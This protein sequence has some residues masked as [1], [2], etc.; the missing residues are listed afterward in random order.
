MPDVSPIAD[1][2]RWKIANTFEILGGGKGVSDQLLS[3]LLDPRSGTSRGMLSIAVAKSKNRSAIPVLLNMLEENDFPG[4]AAQGLG[5]LR[6][7]EAVPK[8]R[9][10]AKEHGN[11]WVRQQAKTALRRLGVTM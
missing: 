4:F 3:L 6:A 9:E 5:I 2:F 7:E 1:D 8:L 10:V 11:P